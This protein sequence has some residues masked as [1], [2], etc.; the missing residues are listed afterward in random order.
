MLNSP[1]VGLGMAA[2]Q[3]KGDVCHSSDFIVAD[4][5]IDNLSYLQQKD[6]PGLMS[7]HMGQA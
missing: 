7:Y 1:S 3:T 4:S 2:Y 5:V 6:Q